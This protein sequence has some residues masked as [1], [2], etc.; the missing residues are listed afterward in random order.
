MAIGK[1]PFERNIDRK[2]QK[3]NCGVIRNNSKQRRTRYFWNLKYFYRHIFLRVL[4]HI[5][6]GESRLATVLVAFW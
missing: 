4:L 2:A 3:S 6:Q 5:L 1:K